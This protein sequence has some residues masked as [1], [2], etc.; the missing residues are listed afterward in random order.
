MEGEDGIGIRGIASD[1]PRGRSST[2]PMSKSLC[3]ICAAA[4]DIVILDQ[5]DAAKLEQKINN[6]AEN[7]GNAITWCY[8]EKQEV[9]TIQKEQYTQQQM[10]Q[11]SQKQW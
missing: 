6:D 7:G 3:L 11:W 10:V 2:G 9:G 1:G 5:S 4:R 8:L